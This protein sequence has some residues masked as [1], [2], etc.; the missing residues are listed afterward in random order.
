MRNKMLTQANTQI[1]AS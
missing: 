1:H